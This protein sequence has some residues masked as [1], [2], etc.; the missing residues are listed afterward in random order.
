LGA[1][2]VGDFY[3]LPDFTAGFRGV[4]Q[5]DLIEPRAFDLVRRW[6]FAPEDVAE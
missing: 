5:Q 6:I 1:D 4:V 3:S 2:E